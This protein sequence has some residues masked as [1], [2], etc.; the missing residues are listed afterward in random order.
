MSHLLVR[1]TR[2]S[3]QDA[4]NDILPCCGSRA[5]AESMAAKRPVSDE[6]SLLVTSDEAW[7]ALSQSDWLEAFRGHPRI[8]ESRTEP[9]ATPKSCGWPARE[10]QNVTASDDSLNAALLRRKPGYE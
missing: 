5:W 3:H 4:V 1:W 2:L 7:R 10:H 9:S 8:G 6:T